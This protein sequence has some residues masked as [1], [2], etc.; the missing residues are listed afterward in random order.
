M[1][2]ILAKNLKNAELLETVLDSLRQ[3]G[4]EIRATGL[5]AP[6]HV[7]IDKTCVKGKHYVRLRSD[8]AIPE[9]GDRSFLPLGRVGCPEH[10]DWAA[11]V[12]RQLALQELERR[13]QI[14]QA[15][16]ESFRCEIPG[17]AQPDNVDHLWW[18]EYLDG[19]SQQ[20]FYQKATKNCDG[21]NGS[22][23]Y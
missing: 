19:D 3:Q 16:I 22:N 11:R 21:S 2:T 4:E 12:S 23:P 20:W 15:L 13:S 10:R 17:P 5:V 6:P 14:L 9:W 8:R 1:S 18:T 7:W